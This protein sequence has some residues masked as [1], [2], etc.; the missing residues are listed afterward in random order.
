MARDKN[1]HFSGASALLLEGYNDAEVVK[2]IA[3]REGLALASNLGLYSFFVAS[4][5]A[6]AVRSFEGEGFDRYGAFN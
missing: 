3:R 4:H 1:G 2:E 5:C 6:N